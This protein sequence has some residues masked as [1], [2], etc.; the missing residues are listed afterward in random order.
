M[1]PPFPTPHST[2]LSSIFSIYFL[3][4][5]STHSLNQIQK[6][7]PSSFIHTYTFLPKHQR[8]DNIMYCKNIQILLIALL[9]LLSAANPVVEMRNLV[10]R[11]DECFEF[12]TLKAS[13]MEESHADQIREMKVVANK[14]GG[15]VL[16]G[17]T[18]SFCKEKHEK[19]RRSESSGG[20]ECKKAEETVF[21]LS[22]KKI[23]L[24]CA[25]FSIIRNILRS[26]ILTNALRRTQRLGPLKRSSS[27]KKQL[28]SNLLKVAKKQ[29]KKPKRAWPRVSSSRTKN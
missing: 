27:L 17:E 18:K 10:A 5:I 4:K 1:A 28:Y 3:S 21:N 15:L 22:S 9:P 24:V 14:E 23:T 6:S 19:R 7:L 11:S 16:G 8:P 25:H 13:A 29:R 26:M 20:A 2:A 12:F